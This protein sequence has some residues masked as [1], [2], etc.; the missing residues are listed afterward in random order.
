[1]K[2]GLFT[3]ACLWLVFAALDT[4]G[5]AQPDKAGR[6]VALVDLSQ[7]AHPRPL[8]D[9]L[10]VKLGTDPDLR[11]LERDEIGRVKTEQLLANFNSSNRADIVKLG[12]LLKAD[13]FLLLEES[14]ANESLT[15]IRI[16]VVDAWFGFKLLDFTVP[17][18]EAGQFETM[19][20]A[21]ARRVSPR[22]KTLPK[23]PAKLRLVGVG[24]FRSEEPA[25]RSWD[26]LGESIRAGVERCLAQYQG[27]IVLERDK[28]GALNGERTLV[29]GLPE[30]LQTS[31]IFVDG[32]FALDRAAGSGH[33]KVY[34]RSRNSAGQP[35]EKELSSEVRQIEVLCHQIAKDVVGEFASLTSTNLDASIESKLLALEAEYYLRQGEALA[36][37]GPAESALALDPANPH[38]K[39]LV[40]RSLKALTDYVFDG[41]KDVAGLL[42]RWR[43]TYDRMFD[44]ADE[45][46]EHTPAGPFYGEVHGPA[47]ALL[48]PLPTGNISRGNTPAL[49]VYR[50][51]Q[52]RQRSLYE[53]IYADADKHPVMP[54][55]QRAWLLLAAVQSG[56]DW[57]TTAAA[58]LAARRAAYEK[59]ADFVMKNHTGSSVAESALFNAT[60]GY[61]NH[62]LW[63]VIERADALTDKFYSELSESSNFWLRAAAAQTLALRQEQL[64]EKADYAA[65]RR[66]VEQL[67]QIATEQIFSTYP[68]DIDAIHAMI[69]PTFVN[70]RFDADP[71]ASEAFKHELLK[72][73][74]SRA[75]AQAEIGRPHPPAPPVP[76]SPADYHWQKLVSLK[77]CQML[78][79]AEN[80]GANFRRIIHTEGKLAVVCALGYVMQ[81]RPVKL[82]LVWLNPET[83]RPE[84]GQSYPV[85]L[86]PWPQCAFFLENGPDWA[87]A[88]GEIYLATPNN[89]LLV[90]SPAHSP[91]VLDMEQ[92]LVANSVWQPAIIGH[93]LYA[94]VNPNWRSEYEGVM[95]LDLSNNVSRTLFSTRDKQRTGLLSGT[96]LLGLAA[97][98]NA[99]VLWLLKPNQICTHD[100]ATGTDRAESFPSLENRRTNMFADVYDFRGYGETLVNNFLRWPSLIRM[101]SRQIVELP[102]DFGHY[103]YLNGRVIP[104][105]DGAVGYNANTLVA[106]QPGS[107]A[108]IDVLARSTGRDTGALRDICPTPDGLLALTENVLYRVPE[109][110]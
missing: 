104:V 93:K 45:L 17:A 94:L 103:H 73:Y 38:N 7:T 98:P 1:M 22:L 76:P 42:C 49:D 44:L 64:R 14:G 24:P 34:V 11:L 101:R 79:G 48:G 107:T 82:G 56:G 66:Y 36:A 52:A 3:V 28:L 102:G 86:T 40:L 43:E 99:N 51:L 90:F 68:Q 80:A 31:G 108:V 12:Q 77:E 19:A 25:A 59:A 55:F 96:V 60:R 18:A 72:R 110:R 29:E 81:K 47:A 50:Q 78:P 33:L 53:H 27:V 37:T 97:D 39:L 95:E 87:A 15:A 67:A 10:L 84:Q 57:H 61:S 92:S 46:V 74:Y 63:D 62:P 23:D 65:A 109:L 75:P 88:G 41:E 30:K 26:Y 20:A 106:W 4:W 58:T 13:V 89:G 21:I 71:K 105:G 91:R 5:Q 32:A 54:E 16:R 70:G 2:N 35:Q 6:S 83:G 69:W 9:L 100:L 8:A 85:E